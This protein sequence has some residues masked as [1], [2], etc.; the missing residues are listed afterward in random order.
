MDRRNT[1]RKHAEQPRRDHDAG[2]IRSAS[3]NSRRPVARD[4]RPLTDAEIRERN[5]RR[6]LAQERR[7]KQRT[8]RRIFVGVAVVCMLAALVLVIMMVSMHLEEREEMRVQQQLRNAFAQAAA[9]AQA[10]DV[11]QNTTALE[12]AETPEPTAQMRTEPFVSD[13]LAALSQQNPDMIGWISVGGEISTPVVLRDNDYY[14]DHD[15]YG[16]ESNSGTV[17]ADEKNVDW[18]NDQYLVLYGHNMRMGTMFG[19]LDEYAD[20]EYLKQNALVEFQMLYNNE[21]RQYVPFAVVDAS[22]DDDHSSFFLLRQ[23]DIFA[24]ET[25]DEQAIIDFYAEMLNRSMTAIPGVE[26]APDDRIIALVTCSYDMPDARFMVFCREL[27][28]GE[29]AEQMTQQVQTTAVKK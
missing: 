20:V 4:G 18:Q 12:A 2:R 25:R 6:R 5:R 21:V 14:M 10:T 28:D 15:F 1:N 3:Q 7:R 22:M 26:V 24:G 19:R 27:R 11:P 13:K 8:R 17:F 29:T 16:N 9:T 23:F